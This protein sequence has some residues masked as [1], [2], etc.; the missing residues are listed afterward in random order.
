[1]AFE[2]KKGDKFEDL[3]SLEEFCKNF[4]K[5]KIKIQDK[6]EKRITLN[7]KS[8]QD[9]EIKILC[10]I[11][12]S[13]IIRNTKGFPKDFQDYRLLRITN[14]NGKKMIRLSQKIAYDVDDLL[15]EPNSY[16][17]LVAF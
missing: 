6:A 17:D 11:A 2:F 15:N 13:E 5:C 12:L 4:G 16:E 14:I 1:M 7:I 3:G 8:I 10:S 9:V